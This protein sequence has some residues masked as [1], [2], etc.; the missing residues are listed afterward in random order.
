MFLTAGE[1]I[2]PATGGLQQKEMARIC[3]LVLSGFTITFLA[4]SAWAGD[5]W[6]DKAYPQ[7]D[8]NNDVRRILNDS[9]W[10]KVAHVDLPGANLTPESGLPGGSAAISGSASKHGMGVGGGS[11]PSGT[12]P[13]LGNKTGANL[14]QT[15]FALWWLSSHALREAFLR[16]AELS[17]QVR[18]SDA[19]NGFSTPKDAYEIMVAGLRWEDFE[20]AGE[21]TLKEEVALTSKKAREKIAP[22]K[23]NAQRTP[24]REKT[25]AIVFSFLKQSAS[26]EATIGS[27]EKGVEFSCALPQASFKVSFDIPPMGDLK[28]RDL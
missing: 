19:E 28:G 10:A 8:N 7:W 24:D 18:E 16:V 13:E 4:A 3:K 21:T 1:G 20:A 25:Q 14:P 27:A 5:V 17:G 6:K 9:P 26:G 11:A 15:P 2:G 23:V 12:P 22:T